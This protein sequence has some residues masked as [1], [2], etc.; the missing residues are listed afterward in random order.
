MSSPAQTITVTPVL[1]LQF[2][3]LETVSQ[4][5]DCFIE[6]LQIAEN[7]TDPYSKKCAEIG[8]ELGAALAG[9]RDGNAV[10][11]LICK[12]RSSFLNVWDGETLEIPVF[13]HGRLW[14]KAMLEAYKKI[15]STCPFTKKSLA[16]SE[17][18]AVAGRILRLCYQ[19]E[20]A[21]SPELGALAEK[22]KALWNERKERPKIDIKEVTAE[23]L[24]ALQELAETINLKNLIAETEERT[25]GNRR[26]TLLLIEESIRHSEEMRQAT[27]QSYEGIVSQLRAQLDQRNQDVARLEGHVLQLENKQDELIK[28]LQSL[29]SRLAAAEAQNAANA[30]AIDT[31]AALNLKTQAQTLVDSQK[32]LHDKQVAIMTD[33]IK[34]YVGESKYLKELSASRQT[35]LQELRYLQRRLQHKKEQN[36]AIQF[37]VRTMK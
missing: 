26:S 14:E 19:I 30:A 17:H 25:E 36:K 13:V 9:K 16:E 18:H 1:K 20:T 37:E 28:Q 22:V 35:A 23:N 15:S 6:I 29:S 4:F 33:H 27:V 3:K 2:T 24:S 21:T 11:R 7:Q 5:L 10:A 34:D 8:R 31:A 32:A 12:L